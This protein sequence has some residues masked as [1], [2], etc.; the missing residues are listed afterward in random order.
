M[1]KSFEAVKSIGAIFVVAASRPSHKIESNRIESERGEYFLGA[2]K[3]CRR[4]VSSIVPSVP[5][6]TAGAALGGG[7]NASL[8]WGRS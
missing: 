8:S 6:A 2:D 3:K 7:T 4:I 1:R 5:E